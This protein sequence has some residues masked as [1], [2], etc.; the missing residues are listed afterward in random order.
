MPSSVQPLALRGARSAV[1]LVAMLLLIPAAA[2]AQ[3][4]SPTWT[5]LCTDCSGTEMFNDFTPAVSACQNY[6]ANLFENWDDSGGGA[7]VAAQADIVEVNQSSDTDFWYFQIVVRAADWTAESLL[8]GALVEMAFGDCSLT[9]TRYRLLLSYDVASEN[10]GSTWDAEGNGKI[11]FF[12][13]TNNDVGGPRNDG[14]APPP[15]DTSDFD[16]CD[17]C[18]GYDADVN[19]IS[20]NAFVRLTTSGGNATIEFAISRTAAVFLAFS[21]PFTPCSGRAWTGQTSTIDKSKFALNDLFAQSEFSSS[22]FTIDNCGLVCNV[23]TANAGADT[24]GCATGPIAISANAPG[25]GETGMWSIVSGGTGT[26]GDA[27]ANTTTFTPDA[28]G[29]YT[30]RWTISDGDCSSTD[31]VIVTASAPPTTAA[32]GDDQSVC[33]VTTAT[34]AGNTPVVGTGTWTVVSGG[35]T[36]TN[37][38]SPTSGVTGLTTGANTFRWTITNGSCPASFDDVVITRSVTVVSNAGPDQTA[39]GLG[40]ITLAGSDPSPGTGLWTILSG[41]GSGSFSAASSPTSTFTPDTAG[42]YTLQWTVTNGACISNDTMTATFSS[43]AA[44]NAG[45]DQSVCGL[46]AVQLAANDPAPGTGLWTVASGPG[47]GFSNNTSNTSTYT[48][49]A[50]GTHTLTWTVTN[51]DCVVADNVVITVSTLIVSNAGP[52]QTVCGLGPITLAGNNPSPGTGLWTIQSGPGGGTFS[53]ASSPTSTFTAAAVGVYTLRWRITNGA[54]VSDDTMLATF[55]SATVANAGPDQSVCGLGAVQLA[56]NDPSPGTGA[57]TVASGPGGVFSAPTSNTSTYTPNAAGTHTLTWTVTNGDCV[58]ADNV[59]I[60]VSATVTANAGPDQAACGL[61]AIQLA[62]NNPSPG[63]G[64]WSIISGPAG[65]FSDATS[66]TST[67]SPSTAG[68]YTLQWTVTNGACSASDTMGI[69][70]SATVTANAGA[71]QSVCG[72]GEVQLS[73]NT[74]SPGSGEWSI[75]SGSGTFSNASSPTSTFTPGAPG[76]HTLQWTVTNGECSATDTVEISVTGTVT[77]NAG[78]DQSHPTVTTVTLAANTPSSGSGLWTIVSGGTGTFSNASSPTSTFTP[79]A[80]GTYV[81]RW[82]VTDREC[83]ASDT[84][85]IV[86]GTV[87]TEGIPTSSTTA[88]LAMMM[89]LALAAFWAIRPRV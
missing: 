39:C 31:D 74:P 43:D 59:V 27:T 72:I 67:F 63:T 62:A 30:L 1:V 16:D 80:P 26:F 52:D 4:T 7:E 55:T 32:A 85:Q 46:G 50:A 57:W 42:V 73:A 88:L 47:G 35:A 60:T 78:P 89:A 65:T 37:P 24:E 33:D 69:V 53:D 81:L 40:A 28:P 41:P 14:P 5:N 83:S 66:P 76:T 56:A 79:N 36:V 77:A 82:T 71:D 11:K 10:I 13:D 48:P 51:G 29:V 25:A 23:T 86:F 6:E 64:A 38:N 45:P 84:V 12:Q 70:V 21:N 34:L 68:S 9:T 44:A 61:G 18:D 19:V 15:G 49:S 8:G 3:N 54:C 2:K 20:T 22:S 75:V 58:V 17:G 87:T